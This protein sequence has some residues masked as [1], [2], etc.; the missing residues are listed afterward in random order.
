MYIN[1]DIYVHFNIKL[2]PVQKQNQGPGNICSSSNVC[3]YM[4]HV[5]VAGTYMV[6]SFA[7]RALRSMQIVDTQLPKRLL[8]NHHATTCTTR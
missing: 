2:S 7:S 8:Q 6:V 5:Y 1:R 3:V 4:A